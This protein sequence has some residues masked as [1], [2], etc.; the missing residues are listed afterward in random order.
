MPRSRDSTPVSGDLA[1]WDQPARVL[2]VM[3]HPVRLL[4]LDALAETSLC[5]KSLNA[6]VPIPQPHLSQHMAALR[7]AHLVASH[8][9]GALRCYYVLRPTLVRGLILLLRKD[10]PVKVRDRAAVRQEA[11]RNA[12]C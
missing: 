1:R 3:S 8:K 6:L 5:V 4:I 11:R 12:S 9:D 7:K 2:K 10:H